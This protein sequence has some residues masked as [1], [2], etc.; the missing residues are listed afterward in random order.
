MSMARKKYNYKDKKVIVSLFNESQSHHNRYVEL[1]EGN[2]EE[3]QRELNIAGN[4]LQQAF[5]LGLKC[6]LNRRYKELFDE[7][8]LAW[9]DQDNFVKVIENGHQSNGQ[10]V[11]MRYLFAQMDLYANPKLCDSGIDFS[12]IRRNVHSISNDN[13][14]KGNDVEIQKYEES[15]SE[16]RKFIICYIDSNP[17]IQMIQSPEFM[18]LQQACDYW[19]K[20]SRYNYC[21]I[22]DKVDLDEKDLSKILY[23]NW[24]LIIDFDSCSGRNGLIH[25]YQNE[26]SI[27]PN[28]FDIK[29]P[30]QTFFNVASNVPYWFLA[31]G[32]EDIP[33]TVTSSD[34]KW[35]QK[36]GAQLLESFS[37]YKEAFSKPIKV[38]ILNG[39]ATYIQSILSALDAVYEDLLKVFLLSSEVQYD[40]IREQYKDDLE[41]YPLTVS[42]FAQGINNF[43]ALFERTISR[44]EYYICG[45]DGQVGIKLEDYS[46]FEIPYLGIADNTFNEIEKDREAFYQGR[47]VLSWYGAKNG[48]AINRIR[49][50]RKIKKS[51]LDA[52]N[53]TT[54]KIIEL[55]HDPGAGGTTL[56]RLISYEL[57]KE[58]PVVLL[59]VYNEKISCKQ[60][61]NLYRVVRMSIVIVVEGSLINVENLQKFN[62]ELMSNAIPHVILY[63]NRL[64]KAVKSTD[65]DLKMLTDDEFNEMFIKLQPYIDENKQNDVNSLSVIPIERYPFFMS[66]KAFDE[67][68]KGVKD[69]IRHYM[70]SVSLNDSK[71]LSYI[72]LVDRFANRSLDINFLINC[73]PD[74]S[75]GIFENEINKNLI[76][77][78][79]IGQNRY[80]KTRH[81]RF[82]EEIIGEKIGIGNG[83]EGQKIAENLSTLVR[84]FISYSKQNIM[85]DLDSTMDIL[86]NLLI[87]RDT[88][89]LVKNKF[90]Q[91]IEYMKDQIPAN[92]EDTEKYNCIGL[93]FKELVRV[94]PDEAH[95]RA[96]LSRY[97]TYIE[98]N[99]EKG[100]QEANDAVELAEQQDIYDSLLY[101]IS[102][103]SI[104]RY[105]EEKLYR[106]ALDCQTFGEEQACKDKVTDIRNELE[107]ASNL[108]EKVR[109]TNNKVA[110][111]I[112][113]I[114]MC[115]SVVDFG[116]ELYSC[117]T[118]EFVK[119]YKDSWFMSYYDRA[120]T[121]ME[122]FRNIQVEEDTEFYKVRLT[123]RCNE[124][125]QDMLYNIETTVSMWEEYL[126]KANDMQKPVIRRF[127]ARAKEKQLYNGKE[128]SSQN[129]E[130]VLRLMEENIKQEPSNG[131]NIR[132]WF[133]ALRYSEENNSD[134]LL[135]EAIQ[136]LGTWKQLGDNF[137]AYYYYFIL[138]CI[139]AI[140]GSSRAEAV[141]PELQEQLKSKTAHMPNNRVIYEWLGVGRGI[142]R[143]LN[144]YTVKN[145]KSHRRS[146]EE[147]EEKACCIEG[148]ISKYRSDRSAQIRAYNM[149]VFFSP[150][151]QIIQST[152]EDINKKVSFVLGFSYDGLRAL[153]RS[154]KLCDGSDEKQENDT[155]VGKVVRCS[156]IG[157]DTSNNYVKVKFVDF[158]NTFGS[159]HVSQLPDEKTIFDYS[160][161]DVIYGKIESERFVERERRI[162]YQ[163]SMREKELDEWQKQLQAIKNSLKQ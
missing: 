96:H 3:A 25:A 155:L 30:K 78:N 93:V 31:N 44:E 149:E 161:G 62:G 8:I 11:D 19:S 6:Y 150:S 111:Y 59:S 102:G 35:N 132:I 73:N 135:D 23:I 157:K 163:V 119:K 134:I 129:V 137:E 46:C 5:E 15:Y 115:I 125:L 40:A 153:N 103:M 68:F 2:P 48:F 159:V 51:I 142:G 55:K 97:Y 80:V 26:Y 122:G 86:K 70:V 114:E 27:Q 65:D 36:Y 50:Y 105:V 107:K 136:K 63:V 83:L 17:P 92:A 87:L 16:I 42:E 60:I 112:S 120:L 54:S 151:G 101:H 104:R 77:V 56:A 38:I 91:V 89:S 52:C 99:Y 118:E 147:I 124:S 123:T 108:F 160:V 22:C 76:S 84:E 67:K 66:M 14:H 39:N 130:M 34:R 81:P 144:A 156:V 7:H 79:E 133:N 49:Q 58:M 72:A 106:A 95:F 152:A 88:D 1:K 141:I 128:I 116:K 131:A 98:K 158:Q 29:N 127:I 100:I 143:L 85:Y 145:G 75:L 109:V 148:R 162:Y 71:N 10:M 61:I 12:L 138:I 140:E 74:D 90:S 18:N 57:S 45:K 154:V 37:R 4:K 64:S 47:C 117:S 126:A 43:S 24:S 9:R 121:L 13:K 28:Y 113:D 33:E 69:Y 94:Y 146:L 53:E 139:K 21:L 82:A 20:D 32:V 41:Y 110:G